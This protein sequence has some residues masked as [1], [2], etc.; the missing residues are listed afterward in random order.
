[1]VKRTI[2]I[3]TILLILTMVGSL[4]VVL[5]KA[6]F[7]ADDDIASGVD[8]TC[9]WEIDSEGIFTIRPMNGV[10]GEIALHNLSNYPSWYYYAESIKKVVV[11][12]GVKCNSTSLLTFAH[13]KN[14]TEMDILNLDT[15][16][17]TNM[18]GMFDG[19]SSIQQIDLSNFDTSKV[20]HMGW[21]FYG[22]SSL[23]SVDL[24]GFDTSSIEYTWSMF[25]ECYELTNLDLSSFKTINA[26]SMYNMFRNCSKLSSLDI[27]GLVV[28]DN[29]EIYNMFLGCNN[30]KTVK[31][32]K[33]FRFRSKIDTDS[34][35]FYNTTLPTPSSSYP[36]TGKWIIEDKEYGPYTSEE[37]GQ[38]YDGN[39]MA[40][41]WVWEQKEESI[42]DDPDEPDL[43]EEN[44][45]RYKVEYFFDGV[46]DDS[47]DESFNAELDAIVSATPV[48][49]F[50]HEN[51][52]YTL[53]SKNHDITI[54]INDKDNII[55]VYYETDVLDYAIDDDEIEGDGIPDKYQ[56][57]ITYKVENG[58]WND[59]TNKDKVDVITLYDKDGNLSE[60]GSGS[61]KIPEVGSK[62]NE[63]YTYGYW[64]KN[65]PSKVSKNDD[66]KEY[67]YS[68]ETVKAI[69]DLAGGKGKS[70]NP[71]TGD[72][73]NKYLLVGVGGILVLLLVSRIRRKYSRKAKKIQF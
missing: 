7:A 47:L 26:T 29:A 57:G 21:M 2:T 43:P 27:S 14:C 45:H 30:L 15:S 60:E 1:M 5:N 17:A 8:G 13:M 16:N 31:L 63:G 69:E 3:T 34:S 65:V 9:S 42:P 32:G 62:P 25:E 59:G 6:S 72:V 64:N 11:E 53:V 51:R 4:I 67:V 22:C 19:C 33:D 24:S 61:T 54:S 71:K 55:K 73:M 44:G 66:D 46:L 20:T 68:Y 12:P 18:A 50:K 39:T 10:S 28:N 36:Y 41:T 70:F 38:V 37:L 49:P 56:I 58:S 40:G 35:Y 48:T 52:N 23:K